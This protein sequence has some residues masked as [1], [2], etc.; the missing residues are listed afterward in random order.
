MQPSVNFPPGPFGMIDIIDVDNVD[1]N[2][3][4]QL[5]EK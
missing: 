3:F 5:C 1:D 2:I 4:C